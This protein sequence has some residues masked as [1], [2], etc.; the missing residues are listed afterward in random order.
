MLRF[1]ASVSI[2]TLLLAVAT[3]LGARRGWWLLPTYLEEILFLV[4]CIAMAVYYFLS[5]QQTGQS[6]VQAYLLSIT[7]KMA[8]GLALIFF[9]VWRD[10]SSAGENAALFVISYL[11][12]TLLEVFFLLKKFR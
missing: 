6:F 8:F 4:V 9:I 7:L 11:L 12:F 3:S 5:K 2:A 1:L 10:P